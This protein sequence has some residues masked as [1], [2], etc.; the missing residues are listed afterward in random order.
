LVE[1]LVPGRWSE[2]R[3]PS[4]QELK[5]TA[6]LEMEIGEAS[7]KTKTGGSD[8]DDS[9]DAQRDV[10]AG[11]IPINTAYGTPLPSPRLRARTPLSPSV[12]RLIGPRDRSR[13]SERPVEGTHPPAVVKRDRRHTAQPA[14]AYFTTCVDLTV[15]NVSLA[16]IGRDLTISRERGRS[17]HRAGRDGP[18]MALP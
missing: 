12:H 2:L 15:V 4:R 1:T 5:G 3:P 7:V 11:V 6:I 16:T 10:W 14:V 13:P 17:P 9:P 8:D 18:G